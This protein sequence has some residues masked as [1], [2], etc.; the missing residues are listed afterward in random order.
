MDAFEKWMIS[1]FPPHQTTTLPKWLFS[2]KLFFKSSLMLKWLVRHSS[3]SHQPPAT[4]LTFPSLF[5]FFYEAAPHLQCCCSG[6][7]G[8]ELVCCDA[9]AGLLPP[10]GGHPTG[11]PLRLPPSQEITYRMST[12]HTDNDE[13]GFALAL[14]LAYCLKGF[15]K[16]TKSIFYGN[17]LRSAKIPT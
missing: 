16:G 6:G 15:L 14:G 8:A 9:G 10:G 2:R 4:T 1:L 13:H 3:T 17:Q 7:G 12:F 11:H 5:I